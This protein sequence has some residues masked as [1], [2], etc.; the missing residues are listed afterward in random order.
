MSTMQ[1]GP[2]KRV[3]KKFPRASCLKQKSGMWY[4]FSDPKASV[5]SRIGGGRSPGLAWSDADRGQKK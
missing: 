1:H 3:L 2:K 4:V 5:E